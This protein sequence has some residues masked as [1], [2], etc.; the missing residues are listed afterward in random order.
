MAI[1]SS[2]W[3]SGSILRRLFIRIKRSLWNKLQR[4]KKWDTDFASK[5]QRHKGFKV[6]AKLWWYLCSF[7]WLKSSLKRVRYWIPTGF[8][9]PKTLLTG[10]LII[11]KS[12]ERK[13]VNDSDEE[14]L[15]S[16]LFHSLIKMNSKKYLFG[17][18]F[19]KF[20]G[21]FW[22]LLYAFDLVLSH[23]SN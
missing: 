1:S 18:I 22:Y 12:E 15:L 11:F 6:S 7:R 14:I 13:S 19:G 16:S 2:K 9:I 8:K 10:F 23:I 4:K 5:L 21:D 17:K 3:M 20:F